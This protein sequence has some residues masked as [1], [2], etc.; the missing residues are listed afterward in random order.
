[1]DVLLGD[2]CKYGPPGTPVAVHVGPVGTGV[3]LS[4]EDAGMGVGGADAARIFEPFVR[5]REA[6]RRGVGWRGFAWGCR[7]RGVSR[8]PTADTSA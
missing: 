5:S 3:E 1:M 7:W 6:R 2:A 4:V 8:R